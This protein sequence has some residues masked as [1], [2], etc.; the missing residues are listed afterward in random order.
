MKSLAALMVLSLG[1]SKGA[2]AGLLD[3][4]FELMLFAVELLFKL[5]IDFL[6]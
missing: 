1:V 3:L 5:L 4:L 6:I 2:S